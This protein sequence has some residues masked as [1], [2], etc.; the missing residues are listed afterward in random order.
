MSRPAISVI[1]PVYNAENYLDRC[2][3]SLLGQSY[4]DLEIIMVDDGSTD[5]SLRICQEW[6]Q[7]DSRISVISQPNRGVSSARNEGIRKSTGD[8][9]MLLDSDDWLAAD[10]CEKLLALIKGKNADCVVCGLKQTSGNI[11]A[12]AFDK[13]YTDPAS[14]KRDFIY[15]LN[16]ELLSS[17]VNKIYKRCLL[18]ELYPE[19]MSFGEDLVFVLNYLSHSN[20]IT[21]TQEPLY[22]HEVYNSVSLTH[23]FAPARFSNLEDIQKAILDF[24]NDKDK[25]GPR[26]YDKYVKDA[27][28]LTRMLYKD[29]NVPYIRKKKIIDGWLKQ[30]Y[31]RKLKNSDY[32]L[33][34]KDRMLFCSLH[35]SWFIGINLI[36]NGKGY[37]ASIFKA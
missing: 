4:A 25:T 24:A 13:D 27:L 36:V 18:Q 37:I 12:P 29:K 28:H 6:Q 22:R 7:R 21:F 19:N 1:V 9:I 20:R 31:M 15:W 5:G 33:H 32:E 26:I 10:A 30:S 16:T 11:W 35:M 23:S 14:F 17:S 2:I 8:F 34:W 3:K